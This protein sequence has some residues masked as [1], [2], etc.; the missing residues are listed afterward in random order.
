M[1]MEFSPHLINFFN[2][3]YF[4]EYNFF[5]PVKFI[6]NN[7]ILFNVVIN[8]T[9]YLISFWDCSLQVCRNETKFCMLISYPATLLNSFIS[10]ESVF[11]TFFRIFYTQ[12]Q[13]ICK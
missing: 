13:V 7:S 2:I 1:N 4:S 9:V 6:P 3:L 5:S 11:S 10:S 12:D 8:K